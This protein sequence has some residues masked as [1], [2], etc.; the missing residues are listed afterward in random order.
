MANKALIAVVAIAGIGIVAY[1]LWKYLHIMGSPESSFANLKNAIMPYVNNPQDMNQF[2]E[3][4]T[5]GNQLS[6]ITRS[7]GNLE[8]AETTNSEGNFANVWYV[9]P[10]YIGHV[11]SSSGGGLVHWWT[12]TSSYFQLFQNNPTLGRI[13]RPL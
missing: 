1:L 5:G 11:V 13:I 7:I 3:S 9:S 4:A 10:N 8:I 2:E 12:P 6:T